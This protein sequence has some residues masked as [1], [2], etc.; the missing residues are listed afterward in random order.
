MSHLLASRDRVEDSH[1][2]QI[3][4]SGHMVSILMVTFYALHLLFKIVVNNNVNFGKNCVNV[5]RPNCQTPFSGYVP[6]LWRIFPT[7]PG[8]G[9]GEIIFA[10]F[11]HRHMSH[12]V[13]INRAAIP[14][15]ILH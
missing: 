12:V 6:D 14:T 5:L 7:S 15:T 2:V 1:Q 8:I 11:L 9:Q 3:H 4:G 10:T 13:R